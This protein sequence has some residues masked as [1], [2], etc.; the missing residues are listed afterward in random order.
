MPEIRIGTS[1]WNYDHWY[2]VFY[3]ND[4]AKKRRLEYYTTIF[5][6]VEVNAT[7]YRAFKQ[8][9]FKKWHDETPE[10]FTW[11]V[12]AV[13]YITHTKRLK[14]VDESLDMFFE[15]LNP[16]AEK[17]GP[18]LF[19]LPPSLQ[20]NKNI[21]EEFLKLLPSSYRCVIEGRHETWTNSEAHELLKKYN[22]AWCISDT[23]GKY[24]LLESITSDFTYLRLH[25]SKKIYASCYSDD[26]IKDW[27]TKIHR[28]NVD[29]FVYFDN[30]Y[31]GYAPINA[32]SLIE[33]CE[34]F[35]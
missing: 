12:K 19:Q 17:T 35:N 31:N 11:S 7:F 28:W 26:E 18:I 29:T 34:S 22:V 23:A 9:T 16:L 24:P 15:S 20:F 25:G 13:R 32:T 4:L 14:E 1:G 6:S 2:N 21:A 27:A 3:P 10:D 5:D 30:D 8:S 33:E